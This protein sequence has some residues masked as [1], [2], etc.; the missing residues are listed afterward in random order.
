MRTFRT[1]HLLAASALLATTLPG[2]SSEQVYNSG[3][4]WR[5]S[6]CEQMADREQRARCQ[7]EADRSYDSYK[8]ESDKAGAP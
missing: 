3:Q 2:C 1:V 4:A 7:Q 6:T 8:K 5:R